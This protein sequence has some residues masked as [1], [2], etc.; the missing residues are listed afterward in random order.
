MLTNPQHRGR[1]YVFTGLESAEFADKL[2]FMGETLWSCCD[3]SSVSLM[4]QNCN[5][6]GHMSGGVLSFVEPALLQH[7]F[8]TAQNSNILW[9]VEWTIDEP[10]DS[11]D[12][13]PSICQSAATDCCKTAPNTRIYY[14]GALEA[15]IAVS[16]LL[17]CILHL[18][19][20]VLQSTSLRP[21]LTVFVQNSTAA[22][23]VSDEK[24]ENWRWSLLW[25][26]LR[27]TRNEHP[28]ICI[29][30]V[31]VAGYGD[32]NSEHLHHSEA[33]QRENLIYGKRLVH[34]SPEI[35]QSDSE[36]MTSPVC[37][38]RNAGFKAASKMQQTVAIHAIDLER[39]SEYGAAQEAKARKY[40][41]TALCI[42]F[43]D[44]K[45]PHHRKLYT[46]WHAKLR[47]ENESDRCLHDQLLYS[48]PEIRA[49]LAMLTR[50]LAL[51]MLL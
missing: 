3:Q 36:F 43:A 41:A 18:V 28:E 30:L 35:V 20:G 7:Q 42:H 34:A 15:G 31:D 4:D 2:I 11:N 10:L 47:G 51:T 6:W 22:L 19:Q 29:R 21:E 17:S 23:N 37:V 12:K 1:A 25:G 13:F 38:D 45:L 5:R 14:I 40:L 39:M 48:Y 24:C 26:L 27:S 50:S 9:Q 33:V 44:I 8:R 32:F 49:S 46:R 16:M